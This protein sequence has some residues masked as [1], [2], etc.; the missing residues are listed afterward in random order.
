MDG[1]ISSRTPVV[2][3]AE[4][5]TIKSQTTNV[6]LAGSIEIGRRLKEA[7]DML[8]HGEWGRWLEADNSRSGWEDGCARHEV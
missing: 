7:K 6:V 4:I 1:L 2:I 5:N 8:P 3:A